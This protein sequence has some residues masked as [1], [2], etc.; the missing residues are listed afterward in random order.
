MELH[1]LPGAS[2]PGKP[3][4]TTTGTL[5]LGG[6]HIPVKIKEGKPGT[7]TYIMQVLSIDK[8]ISFEPPEGYTPQEYGDPCGV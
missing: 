7:D 2:S 8:Q 1:A 3:Q 5:M 4:R 6:K